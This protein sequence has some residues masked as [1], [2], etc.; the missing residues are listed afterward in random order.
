[1]TMRAASFCAAVTYT[2]V[3]IAALLA[4]VFRRYFRWFAGDTD[5]R[6]SRDLH[7][8][9]LFPSRRE[10]VQP[11]GPVSKDDVERGIH[12]VQRGVVEQV[13]VRERFEL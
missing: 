4:L 12:E 10:F 13:G 9:S 6:D 3:V 2:Y 5:A 11:C 8:V 7:G 1:M